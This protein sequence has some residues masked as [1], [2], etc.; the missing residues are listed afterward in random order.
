MFYMFIKI[1]WKRNDNIFTTMM[2]EDKAHKIVQQLE[3][4]GV[5]AWLVNEKFN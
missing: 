1:C 3:L 4:N 2:P 5:K